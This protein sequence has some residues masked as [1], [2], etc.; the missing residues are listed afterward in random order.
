MKKILL[1]SAVI[2]MTAT[3]SFA[4]YIV[5]LTNGARYRAKEHWTIVDGKAII[6]KDDGTIL[7]FDP[8]LVDV[9]KTDEV[10]RA[11]LGDVKVIATEQPASVPQTRQSPLGSYTTLR[12]PPKGS[13]TPTTPATQAVRSLGASEG[14]VAGDVINR[15][16]SAYENIALYDAKITS[17]SPKTLHVEVTADTEDQVFKAISATAYVDDRLPSTLGA[18][19]DTVELFM[20]TV[21]GGSAGRFKMTR[22]D[23][24]AIVAK[25]ITWQDYFIQNVL[26]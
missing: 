17:P 4:T 2:L 18:T 14:G 23:A 11:G 25:K 21:N 26:F 12:K 19:V 3:A 24:A 15:F 20:K 22:A 8:T 13:S 16:Q 5:V 10:N 7:Q 1:L 9:A 6:H